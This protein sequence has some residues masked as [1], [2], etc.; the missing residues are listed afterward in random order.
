MHTPYQPIKSSQFSFK[1][2]TVDVDLDLYNVCH[3]GMI[4]VSVPVSQSKRFILLLSLL[5]DNKKLC[6]QY[7]SSW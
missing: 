5:L 1:T 4:S 7:L 2:D 6:L 3:L